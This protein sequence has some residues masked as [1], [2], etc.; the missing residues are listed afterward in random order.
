VLFASLSSAGCTNFVFTGT[1]EE[2]A[3]LVREAMDRMEA[4][5][6]SRTR[7][8]DLNPEELEMTFVVNP[9]F[10]AQSACPPE[11]ALSGTSGWASTTDPRQCVDE[12][13]PT[14]PETSATDSAQI[15]PPSSPA[16]RT[17]LI[18]IVPWGDG[19]VQQRTITLDAWR[20]QGVPPMWS[21]SAQEVQRAAVKA[22]NEALAAGRMPSRLCP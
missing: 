1:S 12:S 16:V 22:M 6:E 15:D 3:S 5:E 10:S 11:S 20:W 14:S 13:A 8:P 4:S 21:G 9:E 19:L 17:I 7:R 2:T 18:R